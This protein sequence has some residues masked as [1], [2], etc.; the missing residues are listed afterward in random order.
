[1]K[2]KNTIGPTIHKIEPFYI[3]DYFNNNDG[4]ILYIGK[5]EREILNMEKKLKWLLPDV[6]IL[7]F[8]A[9]DQIPYDKVSPTKE[10]QI[11]RL[12][13]LK[14]LS[15]LNSNIIILTTIN[16]ILQKTIPNNIINENTFNLSKNQ[17]IN[18]NDLI[19]F[20]QKLG[21]QKTS[22]VR[23]RS[24]YSIRGSILD[25]FPTNREMPVRLDF[26][27]NE[28][29]KIYEFD[30]ISQKRLKEISEKLDFNLSS[31]L[32]LNDE[33]LSLFRSH[34]REIFSNYRNSHIYNL[35]SEKIIPNGGEQFLPL[36]YN[37]LETL[38]DYLIN[39]TIFLN[40]EFNS[41]L[42][43]RIENIQDYYMARKDSIDNFFLDPKY[44]YLSK[45]Y[46]NEKINNTSHFFF[47]TFDKNN[48]DT[49]DVET[50]HNLSSIKKEIDF[51][52]IK[53]FLNTNSKNN[54]IY[55]CCR[56][57]G[58]VERILRIFE[59]NLNIKIKQVNNFNNLEE[60]RILI[61]QLDIEE[62][63][64][65]NNIIYINEKSL[66]GYF[67]NNQVNKSKKQ[68][69]FF[70]ELNKLLTGSV[71]VHADY[72]LCKFNNI[73]KI[74]LNDSIH[75]CLELEFYDNQK[76]FLP[77]ENLNII[78]KY[79]DDL[80]NNITLDKLG[81]SHWQKRKVEAKKK[82]KDAAKKLIS[83][84][85]K[86]LQTNSYNIDITNTEYDKFASTF[87]FV[88][89]DDQLNAIQD[90]FNDF[91]KNIPSDRLIVGDVAFGKTEVILRAIFL[92]AKSNLQSVVLVP[93]TI[94]SRQHYNNFSKRLSIFGIKIEEVSRLI[95]INKKQE[96]FEKCNNGNIDVLIGTHALLNDKLKFHKLGLIIYDE[97][98]KL[99]TI[100]KEKFK[101]IAPKAHC[102]S[103][104]AT[105]IPRTLS[106]SLAGIRDLS[107]ILT[108]PFE[109]LAVRTYVSPF[110]AITITEA[111]KRE[112]HGRKNG[113]YFVVPRKKDLPFIEQ[114]LK[115][116]L[117]EI[118]YV[119]TH[120]KLSPKLLED[121]IS[122]FYNKEIPL[123][124][125]TNIIENGLDLPHVNT[126]IVYRANIFS[127][128]A[129]Y[130]LKGRVGRSSKRGYA[131][132]TYK[133]N[134]LK[135]SGR[136]RLSIINTSDHLGAGFNIA[137]QDLD[138]RGGG[139]IIGEEQSG[140]IRE[141]G[142]ELYHQMLEE[143]INIQKSKINKDIVNKPSF[144][145]TIKIPEEIFIPDEYI[146]EVDLRLSIYKRI[147]N[148]NNKKEVD[149][150][151]I[152][153]IDRFGKLPTQLNNLFKVVTL[154]LVCVDLNIEKFEFSRKGILIG[155]Y[156][157]EPK[158]PEKLLN[159]SLNKKNSFL[160]RPDQK[161]FYDFNGNI[162]ENRFELSNNVINSLK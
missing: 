73:K 55:I 22:L 109:R 117:P 80:D 77:V 161:L 87:P 95:P 103:L 28:I 51:D 10:V 79:S 88:E 83:I 91:S 34:F 42:E 44:F 12:K 26:F 72:G 31:E 141:I 56:S 60:D 96:T 131:Y 48:F 39:Y 46:I 119:I 148:I 43:N 143:E 17:K 15:N 135:D 50:I 19:N 142:T 63:F 156:K 67:F 104:S 112:I 45:K 66:F 74:D 70:D 68:T 146:H 5:D 134:E 98:Q 59:K 62:S 52:F 129:L 85:S 125:S 158:N 111:I 122:K 97:E 93:T 61:T 149:E 150:L 14:L 92:A 11:E 81:S 130:Q 35:F 133:E 127:L 30:P 1:M 151:K 58:S 101:E 137:S 13:T 107:L 32:I 102:I 100:Q 155:F 6:D 106:M 153:L 145:P 54:I 132:I 21:F 136:K 7:L 157:N 78:S 9:W 69:I 86:R 24:E 40:D 108:A 139:S 121:R 64:K 47:N 18:F 37:K 123:M 53:Q 29:E 4:S 159:L 115:E 75:E 49:I 114:F 16:S 144:Q 38:F 160:L 105:P 90:V 94:L 76:L 23:E 71:L 65:F 154:K 27:D 99:G 162:I 84:A 3:S 147:S 8:K 82:I 36:F 126:I 2:I 140:F 41:L 20:L 89:T 33:S 152:E 118:K 113:V 128:A 57:L 138:L 120:G 110:D 25:I 124:L 116:N